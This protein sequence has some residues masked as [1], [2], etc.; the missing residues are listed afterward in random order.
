[1]KY[2][3]EE[4][5]IIFKDQQVLDGLAQT[6]KQFHH[7]LK[8]DLHYTWADNK[9]TIA[10]VEQMKEQFVE[11]EKIFK[12]RQTLIYTQ[13]RRARKQLGE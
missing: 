11:V 8:F 5:N 2:T 12:E 3:D 4:L 9:D 13:W 10:M 7:N 1:M 6:I